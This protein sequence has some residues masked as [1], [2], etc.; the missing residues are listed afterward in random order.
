MDRKRLD[1]IRRDHRHDS[2]LPS[3]WQ[4]QADR[5]HDQRLELID[6]MGEALDKLEG[7]NPMTRA[8]VEDPGWIDERIMETDK[9][10]PHD[11]TDKA[12]ADDWG[13]VG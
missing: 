10:E 12:S 7:E 4:S 13:G 9:P 2:K 5:A 3:W 11:T 8:R 6:A 1:Q